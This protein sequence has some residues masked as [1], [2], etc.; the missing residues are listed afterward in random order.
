MLNMVIIRP[1]ACLSY[2]EFT[3]PSELLFKRYEKY[4]LKKIYYKLYY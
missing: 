3:L 2:F 4:L 1:N